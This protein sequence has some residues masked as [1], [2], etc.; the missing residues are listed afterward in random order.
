MNKEHHPLAN[1]NRIRLKLIS[2]FILVLSFWS[3]NAFSAYSYQS[4]DSRGQLSLNLGSGLQWLQS[5]ATNELS[6]SGTILNVSLSYETPRTS[7]GSVGLGIGLQQISQRGT[8][9]D[10]LQEITV[11][12]PFF[13][14]FWA[15]TL[16]SKKFDVG[17]LA[18]TFVGP[19]TFFDFNDSSTMHWM[20]NLGPQI[21][22][23]TKLYKKVMI[24][25]NLGFTISLNNPSRT[26]LQMPFQIGFSIPF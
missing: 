26:C 6:K 4:P 16:F 17:I 20:V 24:Q 9:S 21:R 18:R 14:L 22:Y 19:G 11:S 5:G 7:L 8:T 25:A 15:H 23:R 3:L 1:L 10:R 2:S 12:D 13:D